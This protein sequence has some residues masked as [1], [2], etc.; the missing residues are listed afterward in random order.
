MS[1]TSLKGG[2]TNS[3]FHQMLA[4]LERFS[5]DVGM[6]IVPIESDTRKLRKHQTDSGKQVLELLLPSRDPDIAE[7]QL[8]EGVAEALS[9]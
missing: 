4:Y 2:A 8:I 9:H 5:T 7:H 1:N 3:D 6:L